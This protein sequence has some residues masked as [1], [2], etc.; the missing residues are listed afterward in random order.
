MAHGRMTTPRPRGPAWATVYIPQAT[1]KRSKP[2]FCGEFWADLPVRRRAIRGQGDVGD[3]SDALVLTRSG[4]AARGIGD[5]RLCRGT[6]TVK[7]YL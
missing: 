2:A 5:V 7:R 3:R 4:G 1:A 6:H